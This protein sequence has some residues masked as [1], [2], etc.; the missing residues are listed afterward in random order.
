MFGILGTL[1]LDSSSGHHL[2]QAQ[3]PHLMSGLLGAHEHRADTAQVVY[4][5]DCD[6]RRWTGDGRLV[7]GRSDGRSFPETAAV[8]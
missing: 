8:T 2:H 5:D 7:D 6:D 1:P 3:P 4:D